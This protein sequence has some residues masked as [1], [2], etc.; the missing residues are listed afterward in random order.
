[1]KQIVC[2][3]CNR[4]EPILMKLRT[5]HVKQ[6]GQYVP[7]CSYCEQQVKEYGDCAK[8]DSLIESLQ[9]ALQQAINLRQQLSR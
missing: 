6:E 5:I 9:S 4:T 1:M 7:V 2:P 8:V 3:R